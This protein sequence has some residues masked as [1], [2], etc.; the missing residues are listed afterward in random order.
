[1]VCPECSKTNTIDVSKYKDL[2]KLVTLRI[3]CTCKKPYS[4]TLERRR[5]FRK[6]VD[7]KGKY[8]FRPSGRPAARGSIT[9]LDVSRTGLKMKLKQ[10]PDF[11]VGSIIDVEFTLDDKHNSVIRKEVVV[12]GILNNTVGGQFT[13]LN[14]SDPSDKA[15]GFYLF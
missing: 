10:V 9:V 12:R 7:L 3:L 4:V 6:P 1:M 8:E 5:H 14:A 13:K 11:E 15:L 2:D